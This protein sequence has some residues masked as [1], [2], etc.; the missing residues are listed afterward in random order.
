[1]LDISEYTDHVDVAGDNYGWRTNSWDKDK[2]IEQQLMEVFALACGLFLAGDYV[3]ARNVVKKQF[4]E[5]TEFF[6]EIFEIGR[7]FKILNPDKMRTTYG[8]LMHLLQDA[9]SDNHLNF[10]VIKPIRTVHSFLEEKGGLGV[11]TSDPGLARRATCSISQVTPDGKAKSREQLEAEASNKSTALAAIMSAH[12]TTGGLSQ[13][14]LRLALDSLAD[15]NAYLVTNRDPVDRML[16]LLET[17]FPAQQSTDKLTDLSIQCGMNGSHLTHSH[18]DQYRFVRQ[19]LLLWREIQH[20]MFKLWILA[21]TDLLNPSG[22]RLCNTG[23]GMNRVQPAP[24][25]SRAMSSILGKVQSCVGGWVGLSVVHLGDRDVPNALVFIDKYTQVP[26][27]LGP[28]VRAVERLEILAKNPN[29][30]KLIEL[31]GGA[32][33]ARLFI[34]RDFFRSGFDGSGSDGGSCVDGRLTSSWNWCSKVEKKDY[35]PLLLATGFEG[36]DGSFR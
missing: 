31:V 26:R 21:D 2:I 7:R 33:R 14:D 23:Q 22:Y 4:K 3:A 29:T 36:F 34:L 13:D 15:A 27:I 20:N 5:N 9:V 30:S 32:E 11:L 19:S 25:I 18:C 12:C 16:R 10:K 35:Y 24:N 8:K 6:Q 17:C 1:V 28:I